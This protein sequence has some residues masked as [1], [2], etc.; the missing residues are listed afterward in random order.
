[1]VT[2]LA[3]DGDYGSRQFVPP[4][5]LLEMVDQYRIRRAKMPPQVLID[6]L[7]EQV[8]GALLPGLRALLY[9]AGFLSEC[10]LYAPET[11]QLLMGT[12][13]ATAMPPMT[14]PPDLVDAATLLLYPPGAA[15]DYTKRPTLGD[16]RLPLFPLDPLLVYIQCGE[17]D[18]YRVAAL[19]EVVNGK[20]TYRGL[21][22]NCGHRGIFIQKEN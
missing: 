5:I 8:A 18:S 22:P 12:R 20:P 15:P 17:C 21:D 14:V 2:H 9:T 3:Y 19:S 10:V 4:R 16:E 11:R 13:P 6:D 1:M 7:D